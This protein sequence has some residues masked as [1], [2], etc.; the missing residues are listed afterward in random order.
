MAEPFLRVTW[1]DSVTGRNGYLVI[2]RLVDG[3]AGGGTR[4]REGCTMEEVERLAHAMTLKN[5]GLDLPV[6]GAKCGLDIDPH[7]PAVDGML[8]RF[9]RALQPIF[10]TWMATGEDMGT[11]QEQLINAFVEAGIGATF[12]AA[13]NRS[14]DR[15]ET[16]A[17]ADAS[18]NEIVEG[19]GVFDLVGGYGVAEAA[20]AAMSHLGWQPGETR[21]AI[22]GFGSMGG[23]TARYLARKGVQVVAIADAGGTIANPDGLDVEHYLAARNAHGE[24]DRG[25]VRSGDQELEREAWLEVDA[26]LL[27]PAAIADSIN[28]SNCDKLTARLVVEAANIPTTPGAER[29]LAERGVLVIPDFIANAGTNGWAW[30][31]MLGLVEPGS[32]AAFAKIADSMQKTVGAMLELAE[33]EGITPREAAQRVA[34][35]NSDRYVAKPG[36]ETRLAQAYS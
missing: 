7:D 6:G 23:S 16:L 33:K 1:T 17:R 9:Y 10:E 28:E 26:D 3:L 20:A 21:A 27:V 12:E 24:V 8:A 13:L 34:L 14:P 2:D 4:V 29:R 30:W 36:A 22:Q 31:V 32:D 35:A 11:R 15:Q 5:G 18:F 25:R 19:T